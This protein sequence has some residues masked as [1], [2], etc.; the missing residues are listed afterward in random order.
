MLPEDAPVIALIQGVGAI[1]GG[2]SD[3][4]PASGWVMGADTVAGALA[5]ATDDPEVEAILFRD[6]LPAA[7]RRS[8]PRPSGHEVHGARRA[9]ASR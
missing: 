3:Y 6:R 1:Q 9:P 5:A 7:A 4:G 2:K 8:P